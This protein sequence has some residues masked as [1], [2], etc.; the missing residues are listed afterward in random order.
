MGTLTELQKHSSLP[1]QQK[2]SWDLKTTLIS[3]QEPLM[4][5]IKAGLPSRLHTTI[6]DSTMVLHWQVQAAQHF[7]AAYMVQ[8][9]GRSPLLQIR[10]SLGLLIFMPT[11]QELQRRLDLHRAQQ[12]ESLKGQV[13]C[14]QNRGHMRQ[15]TTCS[16]KTEGTKKLAK[17]GV[18]A[19]REGSQKQQES[20]SSEPFCRTRMQA[21]AVSRL[22][23]LLRCPAGAGVAE[24]GVGPAKSKPAFSSMQK[25][26]LEVSDIDAEDL[27]CGCKFWAYCL[28]E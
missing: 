26:F 21:P 3:K 8:S 19:A 7:T 28:L 6:R 5:A 18:G 24:A 9:K 4:K 10:H 15:L 23:A 17:G 16:L 27:T 12:T 22:K 14:R 11:E 25:T 20:L 13:R 1:F 2:P